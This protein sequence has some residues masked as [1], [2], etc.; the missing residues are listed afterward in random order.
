[1]FDFF[2]FMFSAV[3]IGEPLFGYS[4]LMLDSPERSALSDSMA[5][6]RP[7]PMLSCGGLMFARLRWRSAFENPF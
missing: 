1:M 4:E 3:G 2:V 6:T 7:W 5:L